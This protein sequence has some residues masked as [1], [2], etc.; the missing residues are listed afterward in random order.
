MSELTFDE[1]HKNPYNAIAYAQANF[2][3][4]SA[5]RF[6]DHF[7]NG[8]WQTIVDAYPGYFEYIEAQTLTRPTPKGGRASSMPARSTADLQQRI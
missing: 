3:T 8:A 1:R 7:M 5:A 4:Q 2:T 6:L